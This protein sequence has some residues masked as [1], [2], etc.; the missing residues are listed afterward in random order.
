MYRGYYNNLLIFDS[1]SSL[2]LTSCTIEEATNECSVC[3][4]VLPRSNEYWDL[5]S[6]HN[7]I[8]HIYEDDTEIF[9]GSITNVSG[10]YLSREYVAMDALYW[11][12]L[13]RKPPF[14]ITEALT[15]EAYLT[16]LITQY[17][18]ASPSDRQ[19]TLGDVTVSGSVT[20]ER[21]YEYNTMMDLISELVTDKGG[22][23]YLTY[24]SNNVYVNYVDSRITEAPD[25]LDDISKVIDYTVESDSDTLITRAYGINSKGITMADANDGVE[26]VVNTDA[27]DD[28][29]RIDGV[30]HVDSD[31]PAVIKSYAQAY[32]TRYSKISQATTITA[33]FGQRLPIG[34]TVY[35]DL[36]VLGVNG[37]LE[38]TDITINITN[39]A[40]SSATLGGKVT[41]LTDAIARG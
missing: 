23:V 24:S 5:L 29:G 19:L 32:L 28:Y 39:P 21:E 41:K 12:S 13:I 16:A 8:L 37:S 17:N 7:G 33:F 36:P 26:Y 15:V 30:I 25:T 35:V 18:E 3:K 38:V 6:E 20:R 10:D 4:M 34:A 27:E 14:Q 9:R 22:Q 31:D 11:L 40:A 1:L 2:P